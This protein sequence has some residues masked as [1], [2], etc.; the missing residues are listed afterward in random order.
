M[1]AEHIGWFPEAFAG[2][3]Q[4]LDSAVISSLTVTEM[5]PAE[6]AAAHR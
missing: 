5:R 3:L 2:F 4:G 1:S 6:Q